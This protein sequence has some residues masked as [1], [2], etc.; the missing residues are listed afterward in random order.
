M[1]EL[2]LV[3]I[4]YIIFISR[5]FRHFY[6]PKNPIYFITSISSIFRGEGKSGDMAGP[7][8][9]IILTR[10]QNN[11]YYSRRDM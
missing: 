1:P 11:A 8:G 3:R 2:L 6:L 10:R 5:L 9:E 7:I 4:L